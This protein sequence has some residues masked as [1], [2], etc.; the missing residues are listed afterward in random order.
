M[1]FVSLQFPISDL[2]ADSQSTEVGDVQ[3]HLSLKYNTTLTSSGV[4]MLKFNYQL[5]KKRYQE[6]SF[7]NEGAPWQDT[8]SLH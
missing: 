1:I 7:I 4:A 8:A 3:K 2:H 5:L 6:T